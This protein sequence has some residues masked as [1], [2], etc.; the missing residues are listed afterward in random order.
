MIFSGVLLTVVTGLGIAIDQAINEM[1]GTD[2]LD[3]YDN[4]VNRCRPGFGA[5]CALC[6]GSHNYAMGP[7]GIEELFLSRNNEA[8]KTA[9]LHP[10]ES[11]AEKLFHDAMQCPHVGMDP[12]E[13][14]IVCC[15]IYDDPDRDASI[16]SFFTGTCRSFYCPAWHE[17]TDR[18]VLFAARLMRDWYYYSLL[19]NHIGAVHDLCAQYDEP[20]DVP[21]DELSALKDELVSVFIDEDGK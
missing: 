10:E 6:C 20:E 11:T 13:P 3:R 19:I 15:L 1:R 5:S 8:L 17:L 16:E 14:G 7:D 4:R 2:E 18:Q 21:G 12:A 9:P